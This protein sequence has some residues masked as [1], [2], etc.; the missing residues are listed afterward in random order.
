MTIYA[1]PNS[2]QCGPFALKHGLLALG[3]Y[4]HEDALARLA[5]S[6]EQLGTDDR[7]L[8]RAALAHGCTLTLERRAHAW[9]ARQEIN[10]WFARG[11]PLLLCLDQWE[12]WVTAVSADREHVVVFDSTFDHAVLRLEPWERLIERLVF[13]KRRWRGLWTQRLYDLH[14]LMPARDAGPRLRLTVARARRVLDY[15]GGAFAE[16][17][18][19]YARR[20][21]PLAV[22]A[23]RTAHLARLDGFLTSQADRIAAE[24][25]RVRGSGLR[26]EAE[27]EVGRLALA[28]ELYDLRLRPMLLRRAVARVAGIVSGFLPAKPAR[29]GPRRAAVPVR[30]IAASA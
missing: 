3:V 17:W 6:T 11:L 9:A 27:R 16:R 15:E 2:W 10:Q 25:E 8:A 23:G 30:V 18:D 12:H 19:E 5:G 24:V 28:A 14:A 22:A 4:A 29:V 7:Q 20:L 21:L 1:Q 13:R 26:Q